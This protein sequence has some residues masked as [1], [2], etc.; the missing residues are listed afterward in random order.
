[1]GDSR[2]GSGITQGDN[3]LVSKSKEALKQTNKTKSV[4][5]VQETQ[6]ANKGTSDKIKVEFL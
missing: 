6:K 4:R 2:T 5:C 3:L 1:M